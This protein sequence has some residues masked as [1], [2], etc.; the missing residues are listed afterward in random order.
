MLDDLV[1]LRLLAAADAPR[2]AVRGDVLPLLGAP[3]DAEGRQAFAAAVERLLAAGLAAAV[4][5]RQGRLR[6]TEAGRAHVHAV[7]HIP[8]SAGPRRWTWWRDHYA[9]P[10]ALGVRTSGTADALRVAMLRRFFLPEL[11]PGIPF[12][13]LGATVDLLLARHLGAAGGRVADLRRAALRAWLD[14]PPPTPAAQRP[15]AGLPDDP[16]EFA[17]RVR[18]AARR[19]GTGRFGENKVFLSHVWA[20]LL[21][22]GHARTAE[23]KTFKE[24]LLRANTAGLLRL[25]RADL[26]GAHD[27]RDV[28]DSEVT[29]LGE[30][31]HFLRLD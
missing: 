23:E 24:R 4:G 27:P 16:A 28:H 25:S 29:H 31:F 20:A 13:G 11:P 15:A 1:L 7:F 6:L 5:M 22:A 2:A 19:C 21:A 8:G 14:G 26:A 12:A 9:V 30:A 10:R 18:E 3:S 17:A